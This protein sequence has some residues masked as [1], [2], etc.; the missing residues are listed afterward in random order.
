[1]DASEGEVVL[2]ACQAIE[3]SGSF[4]NLELTLMITPSFIVLAPFDRAKVERIRRERAADAR[5]Q[6]ASRF[7]QMWYGAQA[8]F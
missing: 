1:M 5:A 6:G 8:P 4:K 7:Q 2:L 3:R